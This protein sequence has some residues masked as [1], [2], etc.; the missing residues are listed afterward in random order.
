MLEEIREKKTNRL[1]YALLAASGFGM[2]FIG[3]PS[4]TVHDNTALE[5]NGQ[6]ISRD[7]YQSQRSDVQRQFPDANEQTLRQTTL[8]ILTAQ[9]LLR[10]HAQKSGYVLSDVALYE[11]I[12]GQFHDEQQ[13]TAALS[14]MRTN[15]KSY[16]ALLRQDGGIE[17]YYQA[18][19]SALD[20]KAYRALVEKQLKQM[21][22][23]RL[24][25][26][27]QVNLDEIAQKMVSDEATLQAYYQE[28][29]AH[30]LSPETVEVKAVRFSAADLAVEVEA[31]EEALKK[32]SALAGKRRAEYVIFNRIEPANEAKS[33]LNA[34]TTDFAT[35]RAQ[36]KDKTI[37]GEEGDF[38]LQAYGQTGLAVVDEALFALEK[39]GDVSEVLVTDYGRMLVKVTEIEEPSISDLQATLRREAQE[40][41]YHE[42]GEKWVERAL[43]GASLEE[44]AGL[45]KVEVQHLTGLT[46]ES[47]ATWLK[48]PQAQSALFGEKAVAVGKMI[49][50]FSV[51]NGLTTWFVQI[52]KR[53]LPKALSFEEAKERVKRDY[54]ADES[55][56]QANQRIETLQ[57]ALAEGKS[58]AEAAETLGVKF[59]EVRFSRLDAPV[60]VQ[61]LL[62]QS[63]EQKR[64]MQQEHDSEK[65]RVVSVFELKEIVNEEFSAE[66]QALIERLSGQVAQAEQIAMMERMREQLVREKL[67]QAKVNIKV[68]EDNESQH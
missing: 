10:E 29:Q 40:K 42:E 23:P 35:L 57:S 14:R 56:H 43:N 64:F 36:V 12:K 47:D 39:V 30:Y 51:D 13:Y 58:P 60:E 59:E 4:L 67:K 26:R 8:E 3:F 11:W 7:V 24:Y 1:A 2:L 38:P 46:Q 27:Y 32:Q 41:R 66:T 21:M 63:P 25:H 48:E 53:D 18:L 31:D 22:Q 54:V 9:A 44:I 45:A 6:A 50:P 17:R 16:E 52:E 61:A 20:T 15:A 28:H 68:E 55:R 34:G 49:E 19:Q 37:D 65:G 5:V 33:A 62:F